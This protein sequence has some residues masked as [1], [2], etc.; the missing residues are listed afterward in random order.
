MKRAMD[1]V[2]SVLLLLLLSPIICIVALLIRYQ[3]GTPILFR[4]QR[5]GLYGKLFFLYKFRTMN[6]HTDASG[7]LL[8]DQ[9]RMSK[10]GQWLRKYSIDEIPQL[11]NVVKGNMSLVGPR[12]LLVE[13]LPLYS[14]K[15]HVRHQTKPGMTGWAQINGRNDISWEEKFDL[16]IWYVKNHTLTLDLKI[17][18]AT[19]IKVIKKDG[20]TQTGHAS[21]EK[22]TGSDEVS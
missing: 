20:I 14:A 15:Q 12:P 9:N 11:I 8:S 7:S 1:I 5:P 2:I 16:D 19:I 22:F 13:Y 18:C 4:Q 3:M 10:L 6:D 17:L 21:V